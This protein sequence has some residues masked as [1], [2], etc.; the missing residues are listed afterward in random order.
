M[1]R[2]ILTS[3]LT[4]ISA[5]AF[6]AMVQVNGNLC[7][8]LKDL[9]YSATGDIAVTTDG[10]CGAG[11]TPPAGPPSTCPPGVRCIDRSWPIVPQEMITLDGNS[12]VAIKVK[13]GE[14]GAGKLMTAYTSGT[15]GNRQVAISSAPGDFAVPAA[16]LKS[17]TQSTNT[18][19]SIG[20]AN[21]SQCLMAPGGT[22][23]VN[24]RHTN[25]AGR[26]EF[27]LKGY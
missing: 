19:W 5:S 6:A 11:V 22:Y 20:A 27:I 2:L 3:I 1:K 25:C 10:S 24:I 23:W 8:S 4:L 13:A 17:G 21:Q 14:S 7:G 15:S 9:T 12:T 16:C 18:Y 26:C